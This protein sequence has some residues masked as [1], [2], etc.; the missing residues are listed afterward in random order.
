VITVFFLV[1]KCWATL[2][3][4]HETANPCG[5]GRFVHG[6]WPLGAVLHCGP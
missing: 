1:T 6:L 5:M 4:D 2:Y 3:C